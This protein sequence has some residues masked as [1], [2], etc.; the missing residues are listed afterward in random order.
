MVGLG[1]HVRVIL[2]G[3]YARGS[4]RFSA[5]YASILSICFLNQFLE[6]LQ[7]PAQLVVSLLSRSRPRALFRRKTR[8][9]R[10]I[11]A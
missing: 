4:A 10:Q 5:M 8:K 9:Y 6:D 11:P 7:V 2:G 3:L 1:R